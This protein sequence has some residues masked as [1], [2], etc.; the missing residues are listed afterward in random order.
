MKTIL[1]LLICMTGLTVPAFAQATRPAVSVAGGVGFMGVRNDVTGDAGFLFTARGIRR[2]PSNLVL[3]G[4]ITHAS[5]DGQQDTFP[6]TAFEVQVQLH[7][8]ARVRS[9]LKPYLGL[10]AGLVRNGADVPDAGWSPSLSGAFG[11]RTR[12]TG[13]V[14]LFG[15]IRLRGF[16]GDRRSAADLVAGLVM[17]L[18]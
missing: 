15:E 7:A 14:D 12:L 1:S 6:F 4:A 18:D 11:T 13:R 5:I 16:R 8:P 10:G 17:K 3:E 2:L 9:P